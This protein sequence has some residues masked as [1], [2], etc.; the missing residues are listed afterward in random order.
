MKN[1][2]KLKHWQVFII[3]YVVYFT[4]LTLWQSDFSLGGVTALEI[5]V[6]TNLI[7]LTLFFLW[8]LNCGLFVN[9]FPRNPYKF[10][11]SLLILAILFSIMGSAEINLERLAKEGMIFPEWI[12]F[13][14]VPV[15]VLAIFYI[16]YI[17]PKSLK[18]IELNR[19]AKFRELIMDV[20]LLFAFPIG[21]WFVQPRLNR[22][23][24]QLK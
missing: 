21:V 15:T 22:I 2:L 12:L 20:L 13:I 23:L 11:S 6:F 18:S 14:I 8:L 24:K 16:F 7:T 17:I 9:N 1:I 19:E 4:G 10:K 5:S 3:L